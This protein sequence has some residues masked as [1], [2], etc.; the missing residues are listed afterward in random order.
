MALQLLDPA[1]HR[2]E[3]LHNGLPTR[4]I[5]RLR[6]GALHTPIFDGAQL[7]PPTH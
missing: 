7:C 4:V 3:D 5:D 1:I 6:L 2:Q